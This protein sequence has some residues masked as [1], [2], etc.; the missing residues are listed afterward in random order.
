MSARPESLPTSGSGLESGEEAALLGG[1]SGEIAVSDVE[2]EAMSAGMGV[3]LE[4]AVEDELPEELALEAGS[5]AGLR[6]AISSS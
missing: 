5:A 6:S 1:E 4:A 3:G 2:A